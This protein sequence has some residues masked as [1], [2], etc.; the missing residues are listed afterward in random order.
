V[1]DEP[2]KS[3]YGG[4]V[5]APIFRN[6]VATAL[7]YLGISP[8]RN[9]APKWDIIKASA[10]EDSLPRDSLINLSLREARR[11]ASARKLKLRMHGSGWVSRQK[12]ASLAALH[13]GDMVEVWL[14]E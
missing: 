3:I 5:S 2:Q 6:I 13:S 10:I 4:Q 9:A 1:V 14:D 11:V 12:P 8:T 7:P